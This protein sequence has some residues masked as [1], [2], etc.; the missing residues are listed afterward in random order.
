MAEDDEEEDGGLSG[1]D[2]TGLGAKGAKPELPGALGMEGGISAPGGLIG[3]GGTVP[4][5][6]EAAAK[7]GA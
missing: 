2:T 7:G 5:G 3:A 4:D 6:E 1:L